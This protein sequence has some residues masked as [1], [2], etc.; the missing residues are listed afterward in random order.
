MKYNCDILR[1]IMDI[2]HAESNRYADALST[3]R[4]LAS[5][6]AITW[7]EAERISSAGRPYIARA[8]RI[9]NAAH[10]ALRISLNPPR[11]PFGPAPAPLTAEEEA[12]LAKA[13][14]DYFG[15]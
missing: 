5:D 4:D 6:G 1:E 3:I 15:A 10:K 12:L 8:D 14:Q 13:E 9:H 11:L 7:E 2:S